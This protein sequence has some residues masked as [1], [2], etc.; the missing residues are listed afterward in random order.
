[1]AFDRILV[2][3]DGS[4]LAE[5]AVAHAV[6]VA[7]SYN[8]RLFLLQVLDVHDSA[9]AHGA[10]DVEWRLY[11]IQVHDY[12]NAL[13]ARIGEQGIEVES[14]VVE[15]RAPDH[16]VDFVRDWRIDLVAMCAY[17]RGGVSEFP[18]GG[19]VQK[20]IAAPESSV[21]V[22]R[23][24]KEPGGTSAQYDRILVPL[25]GS[26]RAA[27]ALSLIAGMV[28]EGAE[29]IV[30]QVVGPPEMPRS[31][32][33]TR[34]EME[35]RNK[36]VECNRRAAS[37]YLDEI[38]QRFAGSLSIRTRLEVSP[39]IVE[40]I[41]RIAESESVDLIALTAHGASGAVGRSAG[42][43][44]QSLVLAAS[45]PVLVFQDCPARYSDQS[46][47]PTSQW[48]ERRLGIG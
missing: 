24:P 16:I 46:D 38:K 3:L 33:L 43:I 1:M 22:V 14:H 41:E 19:T 47:P 27:W 20:V 45:R 5:E 39:N 9:L 36:L 13:A 10:E 17:G 15:G 12:L 35:L 21:L 6:R 7:R 4:Q 40:T 48:L 42:T 23:P 31:R 29:I 11:K 25:D 26:Q 44:C 28:D 32:P 2:P 37:A 8:S 30:L 34:E 18:F